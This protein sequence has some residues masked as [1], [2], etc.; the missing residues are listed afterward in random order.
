MLGVEHR[1]ERVGRQVGPLESECAQLQ[2]SLS[3]ANTA[4]PLLHADLVT[5]GELSAHV[6]TRQELAAFKKRWMRSLLAGLYSCDA[7]TTP[8]WLNGKLS[9][10]PNVLRVTP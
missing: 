10:T 7:G 1:R 6:Q 8:S 3:G 2:D 5:A 4:S 9:S